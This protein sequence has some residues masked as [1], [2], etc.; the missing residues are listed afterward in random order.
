MKRALTPWLVLLAF[1]TIHAQTPTAGYTFRTAPDKLVVATYLIE[2]VTGEI[3]VTTRLTSKVAE[4]GE[5]GT[6]IVEQTVLEGLAKSSFGELAIP[7][8]T[9]RVTYR[10]TGQPIGYVGPAASGAA[11]R[12]GLLNALLSPDAPVAVGASWT[13]DL[14]ADEKQGTRAVKAS[15]KLVGPDKLDATEALKVEAEV[16]ESGDDGATCKAT[17]WVDPTSY[18]VLKVAGEWIKLTIPGSAAPINAK[19]TTALV[20]VKP[21]DGKSMALA[22]QPTRAGRDIVR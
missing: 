10:P 21:A 19:F 8:D 3:T 4:V 20:E 15:Y 14:K 1:G 17:Y 9:T 13:V 11:L 16:I 7:K 6:Y 12:F 5:D 2:F 22:A 18:R